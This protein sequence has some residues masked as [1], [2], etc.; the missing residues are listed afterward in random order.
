MMTVTVTRRRTLRAGMLALLLVGGAGT[1]LAKA[2][3]GAADR[4][5]VLFI[6]V[7]DMGYADLSRD[8]AQGY[9]TP[10]LDQLAN[11]GVRFTQA[12]ANSAVC[13]PTR[14]ALITGRYQYRFRAGLAEP[15]VR[16]P[17]GDEL[18]A[19][20]PTLAS[21]LRD[22]GYRTSL[23]GKW[24]VT[25]IPEFGPTRYGYESSYGVAG[26]AADY[27]RHGYVN[28]KGGKAELYRDDKLDDRDGYLTDILADEAVRQVSAADKR[29]FFISLHFNAPHWPWE[30]P[31]DRAHSAALT[32]MSDPTGGS[33]ETYASMMAS[34]D[35]NVG[36]VLK[37]LAASGKARNTIVVFTSDNGGERYSN[38]WPLTGY[39][40]ELLE[41]GIR[42]P[43]IVRW[44]ARIRPGRVSSQVTMSM[45][46]TPTLL[47]AA[48]A[49]Q[50]AQTDGLNV[51]PQLTGQA[52]DQPR[53]LFWRYNAAS[54]RAVRDG[55]WKYLKIGN[56]EAL[57]NVARD[58]RERAD[59][60]EIE[61]SVFARLKARWE[62]WNA[63]MLPYDAAS[64][65]EGT[66]RTYIDR[67]SVGPDQS[68][69]V[70]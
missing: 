26:G 1:P 39:K 46:F 48:G 35:A 61:P 47:A 25:R 41:G 20:T 6:M 16:F 52:A 51:L 55:D 63:G 38:T 67:Y 43:L 64:S 65:S 18:P 36:R 12:Y 54:Q 27:F 50:V 24:H 69:S 28:D 11:D 19:S 68:P 21:Q 32:Q 30:G 5:N 29:P 23:I 42:V 58:P 44:P 56:K 22:L 57:F 31:E 53:T 70:P 9:R 66:A 8:G 33:L 37:A 45:D 10:A 15:N 62:A 34:L 3:D 59:L 17:A 4:P 13:S 40:T 60:K 14:T 2:A 49:K 7:D